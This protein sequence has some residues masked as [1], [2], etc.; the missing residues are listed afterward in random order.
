M[1]R[2]ADRGCV[3]LFTAIMEVINLHVGRC[4][5]ATM[6]KAVKILDNYA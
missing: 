5:A 6:H 4:V 3:E 1:T 2:Y